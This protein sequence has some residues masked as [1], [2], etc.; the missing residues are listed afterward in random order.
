MTRLLPLS[1]LLLALP[2]A[3][4]APEEEAPLLQ[5]SLTLGGRPYS[6][7]FS[8][9]S[10]GGRS[11]RSPPARASKV[12]VTL[13]DEDLGDHLSQRLPGGLKI[14]LVE[15]KGTGPKRNFVSES[16]RFRRSFFGLKEDSAEAVKTEP[17]YSVEETSSRLRTGGLLD[18]MPYVLRFVNFVRVFIAIIS[19][20]FTLFG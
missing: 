11:R 16:E 12:E 2:L 17:A 4:P 5:G 13:Y 18:I 10:R 19:T 20:I 7:E 3:A 1:L 15:G 9:L 6:Y 14:T 8:H